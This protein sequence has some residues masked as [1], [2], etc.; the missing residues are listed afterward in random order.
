MFNGFL[1]FGKS[2]LHLEHFVDFKLIP[3][4]PER[5]HMNNNNIKTKSD[6]NIPIVE[7]RN[8]SIICFYT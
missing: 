8:I 5:G 4:L 7:I 2:A 6:T 3:I 1:I